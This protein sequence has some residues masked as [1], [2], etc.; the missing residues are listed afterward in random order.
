MVP[1]IVYVDPRE[2]YVP[3]SRPQGADPAK[4]HRQI[5]KHGKSLDGMPPV[6][7]HRCAD[8]RYQ[9]NDGATRATRAAKLRPGVTIPAEVIGDLPTPRAGTPKIGEVLP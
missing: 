9:L 3:V 7:V 6:V 2:L 8:G 4:L 1:K 5:A